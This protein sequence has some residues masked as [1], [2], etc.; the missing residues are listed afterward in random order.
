MSCNS[1]GTISED[2]V[3][4]LHEVLSSFLERLEGREVEHTP[5]Q[6][7]AFGRILDEKPQAGEILF[8]GSGAVNITF[9]LVTI[10]QTPPRTQHNLRWTFKEAN[11]YGLV[12]YLS[13]PKGEEGIKPLQPLWITLNSNSAKWLNNIMNWKKMERQ[14]G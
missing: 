8:Q 10:Y 7:V 14:K 4:S 5:E 2:Q 13:P 6:C 11:K 9:N 3:I 12:D 1:F